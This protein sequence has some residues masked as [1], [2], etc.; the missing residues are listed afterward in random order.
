MVL[1]IYRERERKCL[2]ISRDLN[3][4]GLVT[5]QEDKHKYSTVVSQSCKTI[6]K[7]TSGK[8]VQQNTRIG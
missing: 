3:R 8:M 4:N 6:T 7:M 5:L 2:K 1:Y